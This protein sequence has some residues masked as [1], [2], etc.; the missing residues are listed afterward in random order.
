MAADLRGDL[1][2]TKTHLSAAWAHWAG[3]L[4]P[5]SAW[6]ADETISYALVK[7]SC[8][9]QTTFW[10]HFLTPATLVLIVLAGAIGWF[11]ARENERADFMAR[12]GLIVTAFFIVV[13]IGLAVPK[14]ALNH[15]CI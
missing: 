6:A 3:I 8:N 7:W 11:A 10:I 12:L 5:P 9:N 4:V 15:V 13:T 1:L 14:W 2:G